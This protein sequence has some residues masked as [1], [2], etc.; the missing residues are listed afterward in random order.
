[1]SKEIE[2]RVVRRGQKPSQRGCRLAVEA[3]EARCLMSAT[4]PAEMFSVGPSRADSRLMDN[5]PVVSVFAGE[6]MFSEPRV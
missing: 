6:R 4:H 3:L 5:A 2:K 1:M